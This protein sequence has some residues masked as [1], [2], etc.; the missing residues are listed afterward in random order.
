MHEAIDY[1]ENTVRGYAAVFNSVAQLRGFTEEVAPGA[2][3][4]VIGKDDVVF[5][6]NHDL[7]NLLGRSASGTLRYGIDSRGL[8]YE[9][10]LPETT[11]GKDVNILL[12]RKDIT[13][14]SFAFS[15]IKDKIT[16][17]GNVLHRTIVNI[18]KLHDISLVT[19]PAYKDAIVTR[20]AHEL[21]LDDNQRIVSG[22]KK[23][24]LLKR[25]K[26]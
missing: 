12:K 24:V 4:N 25:F 10:D 8:W 26:Y 15:D 22:L 1:T 11:L 16:K 20:S 17:R 5:V 21:V 14:N 23:S 3:D 6:F 9:A 19:V 13:A 2:F 7:S 18:G